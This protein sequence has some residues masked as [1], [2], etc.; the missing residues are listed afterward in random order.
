MDAWKKRLKHDPTD[1]L[2]GRDSPAVRYLALRELLGRPSGDRDVL[3]AKAD[4]MRVGAV[5][6][7]LARQ[8][9]WGGWGTEDRFYTDKYRGTV[10]QLL[11]LAEHHAD[12]DDGRI[13]AACELVLRQSQDRQTHGFSTG[14]SLSKSRAGATPGPDTWIVPCLT[15]NLTWALIRFGRLADARVAKAI[16]HMVRYQRFDDGA[17]VLPKRWPY[18]RFDNCYGK[19]TCHMGVAKT[20]KALSEIPPASRSLA[21]KQTIAKAVEYFLVHHVHKQSHSPAKNAKP[22]WTK[23]GFPLMY[24]IDALEVLGLLAVHGCKDPRLQS[25]IELVLAKQ[26]PDGTWLL[27]SS[28]NGRFQVSIERRGRPSKWLTLHAMRTLKRLC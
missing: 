10:W 28:F 24:Q 9:A 27:E 16:D 23:F 5:P 12:G 14:E 20:L 7:I 13:Q 22:A 21:V 3:E 25:A 2:L 26:R 8:Q 1:W 11:I 17:G 15:G 6:K 4:I 18:D 19:H